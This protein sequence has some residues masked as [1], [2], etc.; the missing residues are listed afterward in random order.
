MPQ[1]SSRPYVERAPRVKL[2]GS[3]LALVILENKRQVRANLHQL[4]VNGGML[5]LDKALDE[6]ISV[7][8]AFHI[9]ATTVRA[10]A[11]MLFPMWATNGWLQP[12]RFLD[13]PEEDAKSLDIELSALL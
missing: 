6:S 1:V 11:E 2:G 8:L 12:F 13:L 10:K 5:K 7:N 3:V 9:G 4:S